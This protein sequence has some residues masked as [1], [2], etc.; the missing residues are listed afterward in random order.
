MQGRLPAP[1][2]SQ[3]LT[4]HTLSRLAGEMFMLRLD[5][6]LTALAALLM[7]SRSSEVAGAFAAGCSG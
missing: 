2:G 7:A 3:T 4:L 5:S 6:S 1:Q